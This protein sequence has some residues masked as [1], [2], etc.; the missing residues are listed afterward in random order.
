V[1]GD[2]VAVAL[3]ELRA[4]AESLM[5][6]SCYVHR[7]TTT[8]DEGAQKTTTAWAVVHAAIPCA[9]VSPPA[10]ARAILTDEA[11]SPSAPVVKVSVDASG[12]LPDDRVTVASGA[13]Y[14]VV[15]V[16]DVPERT[17]QVQRR[18]ECRWVR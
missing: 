7:L 15:Y 6:D 12:I 3:P 17:N 1:I 4:Q 8:W 5:A 18:L 14:H 10:T 9:F 11:A 16:T 13:N 2:D